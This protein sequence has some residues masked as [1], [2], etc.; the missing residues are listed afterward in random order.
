MMIT[1]RAHGDSSG[2]FDDIGYSARHDVVA[3]VDWI[4]RN[5]PN[6]PLVIWGHSMG[7]AAAVFAAPELGERVRGYILECPYQ[8]LHTA[9]RNRTEYFL[10]IGFDRLAYLGLLTVS[11]LV[12]PDSDKISTVKAISDVPN[13]T[14]VLI[15][16]GGSDRRAR[17]EEARA[18]Y[19]RVQRHGQ[20]VIFEGADHLQLMQNEPE[21]YRRTILDFL[22]VSGTR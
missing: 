10:P 13:E 12:I 1:F 2:D 5:H 4:E 14:P 3:A 17:P 20:L 9:V 15:L 8:D 6:R 18:L 19:D 22:R 7:A 21:G 16:A 11:P